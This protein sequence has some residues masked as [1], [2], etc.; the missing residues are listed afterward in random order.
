[1]KNEVVKE[2][3]NSYMRILVPKELKTKLKMRA[4]LEETTISDITRGLIEG[5]LEEIE[6]KTKK[7]LKKK[8]EC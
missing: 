8:K 2:I 5:Y 1:M 7:R 4:L 6:K 3:Y